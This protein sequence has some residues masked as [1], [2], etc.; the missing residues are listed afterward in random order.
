MDRKKNSVIPSR[1]SSNNI[2]KLLQKINSN[3]KKTYISGKNVI[4]S[5]INPVNIQKKSTVPCEFKSAIVENTVCKKSI[6]VHNSG[7]ALLKLKMFKEYKNTNLKIINNFNKKTLTGT[8]KKITKK[9]PAPLIPTGSITNVTITD[10]NN[11]V[12]T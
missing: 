3:L 11:N 9:Y 6:V 7:K 12:I 5:V 1:P 2:K 10:S 4:S 8:H